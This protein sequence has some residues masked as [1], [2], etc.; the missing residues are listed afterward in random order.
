MNLN[1]FVQECAQ[2]EQLQEFAGSR[3]GG[4]LAQG[5]VGSECELGGQG[6]GGGG[7]GNR[8]GVDEQ[9]GRGLGEAGY[10]G[11]ATFSC[12][13]K[14]KLQVCVASVTTNFIDLLSFQ[15][16]YFE[17]GEDDDPEIK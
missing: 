10:R 14:S 13:K 6:S 16:L 5:S 4:D 2:A 11:K 1:F 8:R 15:V 3:R 7:G 12:D 17:D 9:P